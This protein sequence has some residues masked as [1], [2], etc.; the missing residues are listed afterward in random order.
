M[1]TGRNWD[2]H[3]TGRAISKPHREYH[4]IFNPEWIRVI[5]PLARKNGTSI[6]LMNLA[7]RLEEQP[8]ASPLIDNRH[9]YTSDYQVHR[10]Q[11]WTST[12]TMQS[13]RTS[14]TEC[15]NGESIKAEHFG[16]GVLDL[17]I[18]ND[19]DYDNIFPLLDWQAIN[20]ITVEHGIPLENCTG[21][22]F[23]WKKTAFVS[24]TSDGQYGLAMMDTVSHNLTAHRSW[25]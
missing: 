4:V 23:S 16:Q 7:D 13:V 14:A 8:Y 1:I 24:G 2:W 3:V 20:G 10:R 25:H 6:Q 9:F 22:S 18:G 5:A 19:Y 15:L 11:N 17:Y 12:I 21:G